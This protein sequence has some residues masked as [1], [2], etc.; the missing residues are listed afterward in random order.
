M[1]YRLRFLSAALMLALWGCSNAQS[2]EPTSGQPATEP[3][4]PPQAG[5]RGSLGA[6]GDGIPIQPDIAGYIFG[7]PVP[8]GNY[9]FAKV[10][11]H[12]FPHPWEENAA[13]AEREQFIWRALIL[14]YDSFRRNVTV[15]EEKLEA[16]INSVL[17]GQQQSFTRAGDPAAYERWVKDTLD[18]DVALFETQMRYLL[19]I[20][21]LKEQMRKSF[22]VPVTDAELQEEFLNEQHHVGGEMAVFDTKDEAQ[23]FYDRVHTPKAWERMK[24]KGEPKVR[25][26]SLMTLE[27]YMDLW[28]IPKEQMY[29]FHAME[30]GSIGPPMPFGRQWCVYRLLEKRTGELKDFPAQRQAYEE[31]VKTKKQYEALKRWEDEL[32]ASANLKPLAGP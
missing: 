20:D 17:K 16:R 27:A 28:S 10:V 5:G 23:A 18:E 8:I 21:L 6:E 3:G 30:I 2:Q 12:R 9:Y 15:P 1:K 4:N 19:Q 24:A 29:A 13:P 11:S 7:Q 14:H 25:P 22:A 31:Q 26:V 32:V